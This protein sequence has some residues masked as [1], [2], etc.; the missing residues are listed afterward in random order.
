MKN[1]PVSDPKSAV[2]SVHDMRYMTVI[3]TIL[4]AGLFFVSLMVGRLDIGWKEIRTFVCASLFGTPVA[5]ELSSKALVFTLIRF[6][7]CLLAVFVGMGLSISGAVYQGL[8]RNPLVSPDILGVSA[9]CTFGAALG[10]ILPGN[11]FMIVRI[12]SFAFGLTAVCLAVGIAR[13][14]AVR[15]ILVLV[16]AGLVATSV[17]SALLMVLKYMADP[18]NDLP[19]IVFWIMG[20]L[21]RVEWNDLYIIMPVVGAGLFLIHV[22]RYR[23]NV[24]S[25]GDLQA[26]S[27]GMNPTLYRVIFIMISSL[28]VAVTVSTCGQVCWIGLVIP[29]IART[30]VG[31]NHSNMIPVTMLLGGIFLLAADM[32]ARSITAAELPVSII[33]ALTGAPLFVYLLYKN[34]GSGWI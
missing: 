32:L 20:S 9:G 22:L 23:L 21:N 26:R 29:H 31:P 16:L 8:F 13:M 6:P 24:L 7:R 17:F 5:P 18:Y 30:L 10:L 27:L 1:D 33:T 28:M 3:L 19:A 15:P 25:L 2:S 11:S 12:L 14:I 34:R 4:L